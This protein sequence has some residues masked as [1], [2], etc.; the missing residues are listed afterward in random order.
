MLRL[1][2]NED[3]HQ[4]F[5]YANNKKNTALSCIHQVA[6]LLESELLVNVQPDDGVEYADEDHRFD[7]VGLDLV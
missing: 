2:E 3:K 6:R 7:D 4:R 5:I 1:A